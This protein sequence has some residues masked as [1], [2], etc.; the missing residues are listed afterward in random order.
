LGIDKNTALLLVDIQKGLDEAD[1][2]GGNRNN[3]NAEFR[4]AQILQ[5]WRKNELP[6]YHVKHNSTNADSPLRPG[7]VGNEIKDVVRPIEGEPIIEKSVNSAFIGTGL[8]EILENRN[9]TKL[10]IIGLTT[11]HCVSTTTRMAGNFGFD[12]YLVADATATFDA[13]A[14]NGK[15]YSSEHMH[16]MALASIDKEFAIVINT[17]DLLGMLHNNSLMMS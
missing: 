4:M 7:Y 6:I 2:F 8:K 15:K 13:T 1:Y 12:T 14:P 17:D 16:N 10:V 9:I 5:F 3:P 11:N